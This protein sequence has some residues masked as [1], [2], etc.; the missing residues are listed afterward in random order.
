M[1]A[2]A[3]RLRGRVKKTVTHDELT[4]KL[5]SVGKARFVEYFDLFEDYA[6]GHC[7][8]EDCIEILVRG[9]VSNAAGA[10]IRVDNAKLIFTAGAMYEALSAISESTRLPTVAERAKVLM[11]RR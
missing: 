10:A 11:A 2:D 4:R 7:T 9:G 6:N 3:C 8:R 5:K 1:V